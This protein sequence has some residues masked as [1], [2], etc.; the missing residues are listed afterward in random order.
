MRIAKSVIAAESLAELATEHYDLAPPVRCRL[1]SVND[2]DNYLIESGNVDS[3]DAKHVLRVYRC[4]KHWIDDP[5]SYRFELDWL[6]HLHDRGQPVSYPI[7]RRD[8]E[9]HGVLDA[10]EGERY[11]ALF[12]FAPGKMAWPMNVEQCRLFGAGMARIHQASDSFQSQ[13]PR[14][15]QNLEWILDHSVRR[16]EAF[17]GDRRPEDLAFLHDLVVS[18]KQLAGN[19]PLSAPAYGIIGGDFHGGNHFITDDNTLTYFDFDVCGYGWRAYD[20]AVYWWST[21]HSNAAAELWLAALEGYDSVRPLTEEERQ[22]LPALVKARQIW[23]MGTHTA[24]IDIVGDAWLGDG[25]W[26]SNF[27]YLKQW[28]ENEASPLSEP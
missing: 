19:L 22:A 20:L 28:V 11:Y 24:Y 10:P 21:K 15:H 6:V 18:I 5:A 27:G 13:H 2:N 25:Y 7:A 14:G 1:I 16:I 12:S 8:G 23:L 3:G 26:D 4:R 17:L 9:R